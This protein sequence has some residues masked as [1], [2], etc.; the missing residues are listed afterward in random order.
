VE[1]HLGILAKFGTI[2]G[3]VGSLIETEAGGVPAMCRLDGQS[4]RTCAGLVF[5][6]DQVLLTLYAGDPRTGG[7]ALSK[8]D[9][10]RLLIGGEP[11]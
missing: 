6:A 1:S 5:W 11:T 2:A 8:M 3:Y 7:E 10:A 9:D 4:P